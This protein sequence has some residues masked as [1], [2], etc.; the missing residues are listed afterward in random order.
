MLFRF[1]YKMHLQLERVYKR[2]L[3]NNYLFLLFFLFST[4]FF[5]AQQEQ[6][7][8]FLNKNI[9]FAATPVVI[10]LCYFLY[11]YTYHK[12]SDVELRK[13]YLQEINCSLKYK[14]QN[15]N[16][17]PT[18]FLF[19]IL[20]VQFLTAN[21]MNYF[22]RHCLP[23]WRILVEKNRKKLSDYEKFEIIEYFLNNQL[24]PLDRII[25]IL[26]RMATYQDEFLF[27]IIKQEN[28]LPKL[29]YQKYCSLG[30][31]EFLS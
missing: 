7:N 18:R 4:H 9:F 8:Y 20:Q 15:D 6:K 2:M 22:D 29:I 16:W 11:K 21:E 19:S 26:Q 31:V 23:I 17:D 10:F 24:S 12:K 13:Q 27:K 1:E 5:A 28:S 14:F 30:S 3:K 25:Y